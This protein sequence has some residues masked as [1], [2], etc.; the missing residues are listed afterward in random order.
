VRAAWGR[1]PDG[2][3]PRHPKSALLEWTAAQKRASPVYVIDARTGP[4]HAPRYRVKVSVGRAFAATGE[5]R[6]KQEAEI[7][8]AAALLAQVQG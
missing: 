7:A 6:S 5:G 2:P 8:A 3:A 1:G 4:D